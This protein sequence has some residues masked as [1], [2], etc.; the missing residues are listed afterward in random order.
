MSLDRN[1][2]LQMGSLALLTAK[3]APNTRPT[4]SLFGLDRSGS[5]HAFGVSPADAVRSFIHELKTSPNANITA[6]GVVTF[7]DDAKLD[8]PLQM[9]AD[10]NLDTFRYTPNGG[11]RL[12]AT[13]AD[14]L[15]S[16]I[17]LHQHVLQETKGQLNLGVVVGFVTDGYNNIEHEAIRDVR[18]LA[19]EG[20]RR[21]FI[22]Q[23]FGLGI[24]AKEQ[25]RNMGFPE[26][27]AYNLHRN[28]ASVHA[29]AAQASQAT[30]HS[31]VMNIPVV[32]P[33][34]QP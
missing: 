27:H 5:M 22:M 1:T 20:T 6:A 32:D 13:V 29:A 2:L 7:A 25:A 8:I 21:K 11:T 26:D 19:A 12:Y 23:I 15:Q 9:V 4:A 18:R 31:T 28:A 30:R 10:I 14:I 17:D 24:D 34:S 33:D 16:M 3:A